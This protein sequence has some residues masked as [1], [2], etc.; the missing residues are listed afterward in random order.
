MAHLSLIMYCNLDNFHEQ[1]L[2]Q[3]ASGH[4]HHPDEPFSMESCLP[5]IRAITSWLQSILQ[6]H[7]LLLPT[8]VIRIPRPTVIIGRAIRVRVIVR[9]YAIMSTLHS[10]HGLQ[11]FTVSPVFVF[12][13][14]RYWNN[15]KCY[16]SILPQSWSSPGN[17]SD[18]PF[19]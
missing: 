18:C 19:G 13:Y 10:T 11:Y 8:L 15:D 3:D 17:S 16:Y 9:A 2:F 14:H 1:I 12:T 4:H 5:P 6:H 7:P